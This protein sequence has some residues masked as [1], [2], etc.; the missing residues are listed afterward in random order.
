MALTRPSTPP[1]KLVIAVSH[2]TT[3]KGAHQDNIKQLPLRNSSLE[4]I[5]RDAPI[6]RDL[7]C[8]AVLL[9]NLD[10]QLLVDKLPSARRM[11]NTTSFGAETELTVLDSKAEISADE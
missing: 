10:R 5:Y 8:M 2:R 3:G 11:S 6:P 7:N 1:R 9:E 4:S